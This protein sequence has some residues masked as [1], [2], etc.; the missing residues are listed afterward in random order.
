MAVPME[1]FSSLISVNDASEAMTHAVIASR[2]GVCSSKVL[3]QKNRMVVKPAWA[4]LF[5]YFF[6]RPEQERFCSKSKTLVYE[7]FV[8]PAHDGVCDRVQQKIPEFSPRRAFIDS[9]SCETPSHNG[10]KNLQKCLLQTE[11]KLGRHVSTPASTRRS[12]L[13]SAADVSRANTTNN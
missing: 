4:E 10:K 1:K 6:Y 12:M 9:D 2:N 7:L 11:A 13:R 8:P 3:C 5:T